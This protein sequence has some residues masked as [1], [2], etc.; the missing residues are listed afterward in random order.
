[1]AM[2]RPMADLRLF[3]AEMKA[4]RRATGGHGSGSA[5][6]AF[7]EACSTNSRRPARCR[8]AT[9]P[10]PPPCRGRRPAGERPQRHPDVRVPHLARRG[11]RR[12]PR[13]RNACGTSP[14][15]VYPA[16]VK[17]VPSGE[18]AP[19]RHE[20]WFRSLGVTRPQGRRRR[21]RPGQGRGHRAVNGA[22]TREATAAGFDGRTALLSPFDR[23]IHDR[24]RASSCSTS[25][26]RS[27]C[28]S[29]RRSGAGAT[30]RCRCC[31]T[32]G[33]SARSTSIADRRAGMLRVNAVHRDVP[34]TRAMTAAVDAE[35]G[36]SPPGSDSTSFDHADRHSPDTPERPVG[37]YVQRPS[38]G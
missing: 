9:S 21:R 16:E 6:A 12:R 4:W 35:L 3:L 37:S 30:S 26:T 28:T 31:I 20:R 29:R 5:N 1:M 27:R 11:R 25:S 13:A 2:V 19:I 23:L 36:R 15:R 34:F 18:A 38:W 22:S 24:K 14:S 8:H 32:I 17:A 10:T 33:S 7:R